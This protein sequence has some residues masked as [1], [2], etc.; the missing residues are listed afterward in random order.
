MQHLIKIDFNLD[1]LNSME[2]ALEKYIEWYI[3]QQKIY[4]PKPPTPPPQSES[5]IKPSSKPFMK[6]P[7]RRATKNCANVRLSYLLPFTE[8]PNPA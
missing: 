7:E 3:K 4:E 8:Q 1:L 2:N 5:P 6:L